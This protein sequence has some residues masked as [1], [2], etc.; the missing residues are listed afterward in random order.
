MTRLR[1]RRVTG[2]PPRWALRCED[3]ATRAPFAASG[4][5]TAADARAYAEQPSGGRS[6]LHFTRARRAAEEL[7]IK[8][9][10]TSARAVFGSIPQSFAGRTSRTTRRGYRIVSSCLWTCERPGPQEEARAGSRIPAAP[11]TGH[12]SAAT[13]STPAGHPRRCAQLCHL[14]RQVGTPRCWERDELKQRYGVPQ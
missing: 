11:G 3:A 7:A 9:G 5:F 12:S 13:Q 8:S 4:D 14:R 1:S 10:S 6:L 2:Y